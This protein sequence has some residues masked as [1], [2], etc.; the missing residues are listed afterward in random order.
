MVMEGIVGVGV[1]KPT[2]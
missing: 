1:E 2:L